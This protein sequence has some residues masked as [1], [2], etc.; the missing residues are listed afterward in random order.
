MPRIVALHAAGSPPLYRRPPG[1]PRRSRPSPF[2]F[3][4]P[5]FALRCRSE[6]LDVQPRVEP[7]VNH[8]G[9]P[10]PRVDHHAATHVDADMTRSDDQITRAGRRA[11]NGPRASR[12][13]T[14]RMRKADTGPGVGALGETGAVEEP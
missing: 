1:K 5:P 7:A 6:P 2:A 10:V 13:S 9:A 12:L 8:S 3:R 4:A 11:R 14:R